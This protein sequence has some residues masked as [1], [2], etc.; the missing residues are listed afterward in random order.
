MVKRTEIPPDSLVEKYLPADYTD[1]FSYEV[2]PEPAFSADDVMVGFWTGQTGWV[3]ALFR[4]RHFLVRFIGLQ[5]SEKPDTGAFER[6]I[7]ESGSYRF[8]SVVAKNDRET[9]LLL[10]DKH[11]DAWMSIYVDSAKVFAIT[12]VKFHNR[13]GRIYFFV[14]RPFHDI[15]VRNLLR[16][17]TAQL[18]RPDAR[19]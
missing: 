1:A 7:R 9:V 18:N 5:G 6:M 19:G 15:V 11:L 4:L 14:I 12:V 16:K 3:S 13:I 10:S 17:A 2:K 8:A